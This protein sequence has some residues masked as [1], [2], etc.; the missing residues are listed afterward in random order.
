LGELSW[1]AQ[2]F[3]LFGPPFDDARF[4]AVR[5]VADAVAGNGAQQERDDFRRR[6]GQQAFGA[7]R[8]ECLQ[9]SFEA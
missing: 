5:T 4:N 6:V 8:L 2:V 7:E 9:G 1:S 3:V